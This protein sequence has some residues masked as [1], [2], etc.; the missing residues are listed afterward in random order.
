MVGLRILRTQRG[1]SQ[2]AQ[3]HVEFVARY[4]INGKAERLHETSRFILE[5]GSGFML[6]EIYIE[7]FTY[8]QAL[9]SVF[10]RKMFNEINFIHLPT[11]TGSRSVRTGGE[12]VSLSAT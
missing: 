1:E 3:A 4:A 7:L 2:D 12:P 10:L 11:S 8:F 5:A 6:M 9:D